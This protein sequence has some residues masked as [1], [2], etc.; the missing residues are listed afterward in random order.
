M[1][2]GP[3]WSLPAGSR[4]A[5][6]VYDA[7]A[8]AATAAA[9]GHSWTAIH[10]ESGD[11]RD[12]SQDFLRDD[13]TLLNGPTAAPV[14]HIRP[15]C[16]TACWISSVY[17]LR[18]ISV[19]MLPQRLKPTS[20]SMRY[21]KSKR[22]SASCSLPDCTDVREKEAADL[23]DILLTTRPTASLPPASATSMMYSAHRR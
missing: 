16:W 21:M 9:A 4:K 1:T 8:A 5:Q 15:G 14:R 11:S 19:S 18:P 2:C 7:L 20:P 13:V 10:V 17:P 6:A 12:I 22:S 23:R 3:V